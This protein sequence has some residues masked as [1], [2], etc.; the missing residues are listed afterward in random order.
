MTDDPRSIHYASPVAYARQVRNHWAILGCVLA[1]GFWI[2]PVALAGAIVSW[3]GWRRSDSPTIGG[4]R[5]AL[6]GLLA[7]LIGLGLTPVEFVGVRWAQEKA[8]Q[9]MCRSQMSALA[10]CVF[11]SAN[12]SH[13]QLPADLPAMAVEQDLPPRIFVCP[14]S[15]NAPAASLA[16]ITTAGHLSYV[17]LRVAQHIE[18]VKHPESTIMLYELPHHFGGMNVAFYDGHMEFIPRA[19]ASKLLAELRSGQNPPRSILVP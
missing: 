5:A 13:G 11:M 3:I 15:S 6:I 8:D 14:A 2:P 1:V 17:Y 9:V 19:R 18:D 16:G 7:G 10:Q 4:R 12:N